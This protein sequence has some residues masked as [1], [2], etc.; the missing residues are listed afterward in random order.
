MASETAKSFIKYFLFVFAFIISFILIN[1]TTIEIFGLG[2]FFTVN[3]LFFILIG[4][5]LFDGTIDSSGKNM[6]WRL[7]YGTLLIAMVFSVVSSIMMIMTLVT[8]QGK[9][10]SSNSEIKWSPTDRL[11][12]DNTEIIFITVTT[13]IGVVAVY[14]YKTPEDIRKFILN[15]FNKILNG[16][17]ENLIS[18][19]YFAITTRIL[20]VAAI[21]GLGSALYGRLQMQPLEV[22]QR[23]KQVICDPMNDTGIQQFKDSFIKTYWFLFAFVIVVVSRP[24]IEA[25]F[26]V[27]GLS[28]SM[29]FG[30][31][32]GDRSLI[33]GQNPSIS[34]ISLLTLGFSNLTGLNKLLRRKI[35]E[36]PVEVTN[37]SEVSLVK[38][39]FAILAAL[40]IV[41]III[42]S[43]ATLYI[44]IAILVVGL[45]AV[46]GSYF[47]PESATKNGFGRAFMVAV[48][49]IL[50]MPVLRWDVMYSMAKYAFGLT[51]LVYAGFSIR[52]F[53]NIPDNV[54][55]FFEKT[56]IRQLYIAFIVFLIL[57]Y[58]FNTLSAS[59]ITSIITFVMRYLVPPT[60][61]G[62]SSYL[63]FITNYFVQLAPKFIVQ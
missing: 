19:P 45:L 25:N 29:P 60:L 8:L 15:L 3:I 40:L 44:V 5:D 43:D 53:R 56:H 41:F 34:L 10:A 16:D 48:R 61:L 58:S 28:P 46:I 54:P 50:L 39:G 26:N 57:F 22:A 36:V 6:E 4:K 1:T 35:E 63:V 55:C 59:V 30:F 18:M 52:D 14:V 31:P 49:S 24:F 33:F 37:G 27:F 62:L 7:R 12:L 42:L 38:I 11:N 20:Y 13:F 9:F 47:V 23:P 21:I 2:L 17:V 32:Q 51:A